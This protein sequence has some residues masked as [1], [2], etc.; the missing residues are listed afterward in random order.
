MHKEQVVTVIGLATMEG[1][2]WTFDAVDAEGFPVVIA[3]E[4]GQAQVLL[5]ALRDGPVRATVEAYQIL[6]HAP[7]GAASP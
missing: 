5:R 1:T 2:V 7:L 4:H 6:T 3:A